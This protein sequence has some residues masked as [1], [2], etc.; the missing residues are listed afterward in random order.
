MGKGT[1]LF[2]G[3]RAGLIPDGK[4]IAGSVTHLRYRVAKP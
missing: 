1:P 3:Q 4:P 2:A